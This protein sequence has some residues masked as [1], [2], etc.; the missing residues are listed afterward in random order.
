LRFK[1]ATVVI[2]IR[3]QWW[4]LNVAAVAVRSRLSI[5]ALESP[6]FH[7][8]SLGFL[9]ECYKLLAQRELTVVHP[10]IALHQKS[11]IEILP[12]DIEIHEESI[13]VAASV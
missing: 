9:L 13:K 5:G 8:G 7:A 4:N 2:T 11:L 12:V 3:R 10:G 1:V 6:Q